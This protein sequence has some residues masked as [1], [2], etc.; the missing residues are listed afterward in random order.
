MTPY[1]KVTWKERFKREA[2]KFK[3]MTFRD[4]LWY[5]WEYYK[6]PIIGVILVIGFTAS[7][8]SAIYSNRFGTALSCVILN[9]SYGGESQTADQYFNEG[10]RQFAGLDPNVKIDADYSMFL[11][12]DD[13]AMNGFSYANLAKITA[14]IS[15]QEMDV[16][17]GPPDVIG[18][19]TQMSGFL[20]MKA[21][22]PPDLYQEVKEHIYTSTIT[23]TGQESPCGIYIGDTSFEKKTGLAVKNPVLAIPGNSKRKETA[24]QLI[25][26]IFQQ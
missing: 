4:K 6:F 12:F 23:Q 22:L 24:F 11:S 1:E 13:S 14:I 25:R 3:E 20:D 7:I 21:E 9:G 5:I 17:I 10:F 8:S 26:Y 19:Y 18:H 15:S 16:M 2:A